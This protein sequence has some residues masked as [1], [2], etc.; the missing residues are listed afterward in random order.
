MQITAKDKIKQNFYEQ[1]KWKLK[2]ADKW[3]KL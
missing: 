3:S 1:Q 2:I